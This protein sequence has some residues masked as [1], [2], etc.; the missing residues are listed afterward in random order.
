MELVIVT[1]SAGE[2]DVV[3]AIVRRTT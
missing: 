1:D 3:E 2:R